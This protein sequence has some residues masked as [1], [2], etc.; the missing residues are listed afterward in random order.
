M[1]KRT[2]LKQKQC[3]L[4]A[5]YKYI[6]KKISEKKRNKNNFNNNKK[7]EF[8]GIIQCQRV[9]LAEPNLIIKNSENCLKL[10]RTV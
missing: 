10:S 6:R 3:K 4:H 9:I 7:T 8:K 5:T 2:F 1:Q